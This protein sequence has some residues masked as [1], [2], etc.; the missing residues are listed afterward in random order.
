MLK[1]ED[2]QG[3]GAETAT[4]PRPV[5]G[6]GRLVLVGDGTELVVVP[7]SIPKF[8]EIMRIASEA[9]AEFADLPATGDASLTP[10]KKV[11]MIIERLGEGALMAILRESVRPEDRDKIESLGLEQGID[12]IAQ[13]VE[14]NLTE[15]AIKKVMAL[16]A[17]IKA[18]LGIGSTGR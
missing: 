9:L 3:D 10:G 11:T 17:T 14:V 5:M 15:G 18:R 8:L 7:W 4:V 1:N 6:R 13:V 2:T 16:A 12:L